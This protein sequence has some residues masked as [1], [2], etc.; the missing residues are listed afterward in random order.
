MTG[1]H[2]GM[3]TP[4][5][6]TRVLA[7]IGFVLAAA[8]AGVAG[9]HL[10]QAVGQPLLRYLPLALVVAVGVVVAVRSGLIPPKK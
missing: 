4:S 2:N 3:K 10:E 5:R 7:M 6:R 8:A 9:Y 1:G